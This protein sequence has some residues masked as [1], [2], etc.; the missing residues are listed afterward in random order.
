MPVVVVLDFPAGSHSC[1]AD[2]VAL[3][4]A[5]RRGGWKAVETGAPAPWAPNHATLAVTKEEGVATIAVTDDGPAGR[6]LG[7]RGLSEP[8]WSSEHTHMSKRHYSPSPHEW[9]GEAG[10]GNNDERSDQGCRQTT[11]R[12]ERR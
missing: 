12:C 4:D 1:E 8:A 7:G 11:V 6:S 3:G 9:Y 2:P 10:R 5:A